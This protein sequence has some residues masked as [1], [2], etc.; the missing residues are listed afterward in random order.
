MKCAAYALAAAGWLA[1]TGVSLVAQEPTPRERAPIDTRNDRR[2]DDRTPNVRIWMD[3]DRVLRRGERSRAYFRADEDAYVMIVRID[4]D[5]QLHILYPDNPRD[6]GFVRAGVTYSTADRGADAFYADNFPGMG[7][8]F[9]IASWDRFDSEALSRDGRYW[10]Y[11]NAG[12]ERIHGDPFQAMHEFTQR[13]LYDRRSPYSLDYAE[14][15]VERHVDYPRFL[16][17]QCHEY[18]SYIAW[19]PYSVF[20][21]QFRVVVYD[22]FYYSYPRRY[23]GPS[24]SSARIVYAPQPRYEFKR[25]IAGAPISAVN[26]IERR[27][28]TDSDDLR[29]GGS[30]VGGAN[31]G[32]RRNDYNNQAERIQVGPRGD[33]GMPLRRRAD[34]ESQGSRY[35]P[36]GNGGTTSPYPDRTAPRRESERLDGGDFRGDPTLAVPRRDDRRDERRPP[37]DRNVQSGPQGVPIRRPDPAPSRSEPITLRAEPRRDPPPPPRSSPPPSAQRTTTSSSGSVM[38][39]KP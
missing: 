36:R 4:T 1:M 2:T 26:F 6:E 8:V 27:R 16:C 31:G 17:Y 15:Y 22:N 33:D 5:G 34:D 25:A 24:Y 9:A 12:F 19:N 18:R 30:A 3:G 11:H 37:I 39:R 38:R 13:V 10:D 28:R 32:Y 21:R 7:Y 29:R 20:C 23:Y 14:Y 35:E